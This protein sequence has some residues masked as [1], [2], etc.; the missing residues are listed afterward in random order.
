M[1]RFGAI[2]GIVAGI[3]GCGGLM[4]GLVWGQVIY[5]PQPVV[6]GVAIDAEGVVKVKAEGGAEL[7]KVRERVKAARAEPG[8]AADVG[9]VYISLPKLFAEAR[10]AYEAG[11]ELPANVQYLGGLQGVKYVFVY[12]DEKDVVVAGPGGAWEAIDGVGVVGQKSGRPVMQWEDLLVLMREGHSKGGTVGCSIDPA[13]GA[14]AQKISDEVAKQNSGKSP[15][16]IAA[17]MAKA[18]GQK[19]ISV[20]GVPGG[21]RAATVMVG[22]DVKLKRFS[23]GLEIPAVP[24][25][26]SAFDAKAGGSRLWF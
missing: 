10:A 22:A 17:A 14:D 9:M 20:L 13:A 23:L 21:T 4:G 26:G 3:V 2:A 12:P 15:A 1:T 11:K 25:I 8:G 16:A 6:S 24:W 7:A 5:V 18:M 19:N